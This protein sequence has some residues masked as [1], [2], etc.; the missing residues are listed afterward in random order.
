[1]GDSQLTGAAQY[2]QGLGTTVGVGPSMQGPIN[3]GLFF[4]AIMPPTIRT[5][6]VKFV[7]QIPTTQLVIP[8]IKIQGAYSLIPYY[9]AP[10][11]LYGFIVSGPNTIVTGAVIV[12]IN[13]LL[14]PQINIT[15]YK[16]SGPATTV[17]ISATAYGDTALFEESTFYNGPALAV[18]QT[19]AAP[20]DVILL[21]GPVRLLTTEI[22]SGTTGTTGLLRLNGTEIMAANVGGPQDTH[23]LTFPPNTLLQSGQNLTLSQF[24]AGSVAG[25]VVYA[26]P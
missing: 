25:S 2:A 26:Y 24:A 13:S 9:K 7:W 20:G 1:M 17:S 5:L 15:I 18:A 10:P 11:Y 19:L 4:P 23:N 12:P 21:N 8:D 16:T 22:R 14:D 6:M 3:P